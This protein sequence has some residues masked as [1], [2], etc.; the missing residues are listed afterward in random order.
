MSIE[1]EFR[2]MLAQERRDAEAAAKAFAKACEAGDVAALYFAADQLNA[3][4][5]SWRLAMLRVSRLK[6][7]SPEIRS[8][9]LE[10]WVESKALP[11]KV[12]HRRTLVDAL[13]IL[14]PATYDGPP[15]T[16]YRGA[17]AG[18]RR[19]RIY[20]FS[21]TT[22]FDI[23]REHFAVQRQ[24]WDGGSIVLETVAP[25]D[26]ILLVRE[27]ENYYD[28]GEVV[29]DPFKLSRIRILERLPQLEKTLIPVQH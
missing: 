20:G 5:D 29:V 9:F 26:A 4:M 12:G 11:F 2:Q 27:D 7:V 1:D 15:L 13:R 22:R 10:I 18:E 23:A 28:E 17:S 25:S 19:R 14:I 3:T 16:L 6:G 8:A 21:W 24:T